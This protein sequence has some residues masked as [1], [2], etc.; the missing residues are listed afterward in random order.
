M[1]KK[2]GPEDNYVPSPQ[3]IRE[4]GTGFVKCDNF[5]EQLRPMSNSEVASCF[6]TSSPLS[7][8][9]TCPNIHSN[10]K[11]QKYERLV[12]PMLD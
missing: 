11:L 1:E 3:A 4:A 10:T 2:E 8:S 5:K 9:D 6:L 12:R 7:F